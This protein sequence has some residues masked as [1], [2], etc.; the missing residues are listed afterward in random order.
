MFSSRW[1]LSLLTDRPARSDL[2]TRFLQF[3]ID[4]SA[5]TRLIFARFTC[6]DVVGAASEVG[7]G[8]VVG[9]NDATTREV[10]AVRNRDAIGAATVGRVRAI[11]ARHRLRGRLE[12]LGQRRHRRDLFFTTLTR[13][14]SLLGLFP[15]VRTERDKYTDLS[16]KQ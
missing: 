15:S 16:K 7:R 5:I 8:A 4:L 11:F 13:R 12:Y 1:R 10:R 3:V 9:V 14:T 6:G 2:F